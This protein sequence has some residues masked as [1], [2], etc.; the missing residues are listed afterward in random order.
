MLMVIFIWE[1]I[2]V[3]NV[4]VMEL[5]FIQTANDTRENGSIIYKMVKALRKWPMDQNSK[6]NSN[7]ERKTDTENINGSMDL[8]I[9]ETGL[10]I[11][12]TAMVNITGLI[13]K[14][15]QDSG[16]RINSMEL[17]DMNGQMENNIKV[18][19]KIITKKAMGC[20]YGQMVK[21]MMAVGRIIN[22][23]EKLNLQIK[24]AKVKWASGRMVRESNG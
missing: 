13:R 7:K 17:E 3:T 18:I 5:I 4:M 11:C 23:M 20:F 10:I 9:K 12:S 19:S 1:S 2:R 22:N 21:V 14:Y 8:S 16:R 24:K 6:E 15:T